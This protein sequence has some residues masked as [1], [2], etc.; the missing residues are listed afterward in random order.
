MEV[1]KVKLGFAWY[2]L[3]KGKEWLRRAISLGQYAHPQGLF[4][5]GNSDAWSNRTLREI[6]ET[7]LSSAKRI[8]LI[9]FHTGLGEYGA[10]EVIV[11]E[12]P[13]SGVYQR[14]KKW[15]GNIVKSPDA[16]DSVSPPIKGSLKYAFARMAPDTEVTAVSL[17]FGTYP[18][19]EVFWALW[20]ENFVHHRPNYSEC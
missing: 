18:P 16:G 3:A 9:D 13:G 5:G 10:A 12:P 14:A 2:R 6:A 7:H 8:V 20:Q 17:E 15:W 1:L 4:Y 11:G 19:S